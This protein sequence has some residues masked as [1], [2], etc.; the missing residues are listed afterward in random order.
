[1]GYGRWEEI[2]DVV[3]GGNYGW[4]IREGA[5][6]LDVDAPLTDPTDCDRVGADGKPLIDPVAEY[7]HQAVGVAVVG[8]YVYRGSALPVLR[9]QYV[10]A[11]FSADPTNDLSAPRGS[12]LVATPSETAGETWPWRPLR[13]TGGVLGRFVTG[14]G[15]DAAGELYVLGRLNLGPRGTTG[16]VLKLVPPGP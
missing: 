9:G 14:M 11:D 2:D 12:L 4:R 1:V 8:G 7:S 6:C 3:K 13:V 5:H 15:E 16:E 10:F